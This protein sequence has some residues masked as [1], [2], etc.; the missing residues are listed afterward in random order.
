MTCRFVAGKNDTITSIYTLHFL[1]CT[2][3][4]LLT[5]PVCNFEFWLQFWYQW[6]SKYCLDLAHQYSNSNHVGVHKF[7]HVWFLME[8]L[9]ERTFNHRNTS[10]IRVTRVR[11]L[12]EVNKHAWLRGGVLIWMHKITQRASSPQKTTSKIGGGG[13]CSC[14]WR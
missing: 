1:K 3:L 6:I 10:T 2:P 8:P 12:D 11:I 4:P 9:H 7:L 14:M 13:G 5:P